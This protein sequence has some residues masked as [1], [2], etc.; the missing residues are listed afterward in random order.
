VSG[1]DAGDRGRAT[2]VSFG[3]MLLSLGPLAVNPLPFPAIVFGIIPLGL[4]LIGL[5][6]VLGVGASRPHS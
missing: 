1:A 4:G 3:A 2:R 6:F 5:L